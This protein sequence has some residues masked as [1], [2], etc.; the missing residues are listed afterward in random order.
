M[1]V[2]QMAIY[3]YLM[4]TRMMTFL[5]SQGLANG[6]VTFQHKYEVTAEEGTVD[7]MVLQVMGEVATKV[8]VIVDVGVKR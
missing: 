6:A 5:S 8:T 1:V 2:A 7:V 3:M 4:L